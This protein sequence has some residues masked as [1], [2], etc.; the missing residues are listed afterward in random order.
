MVAG[1]AEGLRRTQSG[2][3]RNYA[4]TFLLGATIILSV[5]LARVGG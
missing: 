5:L 3:V 1:I 4:I 2:Y